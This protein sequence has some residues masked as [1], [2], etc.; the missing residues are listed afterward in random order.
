M[1]HPLT[2]RTGAVSARFLFEHDPPSITGTLKNY[3][4]ELYHGYLNPPM[5]TQY[6]IAQKQH[7]LSLLLKKNPIADDQFILGFCLNLMHQSTTFKWNYP[8][9]FN[10]VNG[11]K[12]SELFNSFNGINLET[13][14]NRIFASFMT[15]QDSWNE[16]PILMAVTGEPDNSLMKQ[17]LIENDQQLNEVLG[18]DVTDIWTD[19]K[20]CLDIKILS[21]KDQK[22]P[23]LEYIGNGNQYSPD[24]T[25]GLRKLKLYHDWQENYC[26]NPGISIYTDWP[27]LI[28][29]STNFWNYKIVGPSPGGGSIGFEQPVYE[30]HHSPNLDTE[31]VLWVRHPRKIDLSD[32]L[33]WVNMHQ[34]TYIEEFTYDFILYRKHPQYLSSFVRTPYYT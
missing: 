19:P 11:I 27:E 13:G 5:F 7:L 1:S 21:V 34:S 25:V 26:T 22:I 29:D 30:Y 32:F 28:T 12:Y 8:A 3:G 20:F 4:T 15:H 31:H 9:L 23:K 14:R 16:I 17:T 24:S 33:F 18:G 2:L 10:S 6:A